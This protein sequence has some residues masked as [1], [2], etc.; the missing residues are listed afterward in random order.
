M[1][2]VKAAIFDADGVLIM[3]EKLFSRQY[4]EEYGLDP[5]SFEAFFKCEF[6]E[7]ITGKA[8][9][10]DL[11]IKHN[12]IW[13]WDNDPQALLDKWFD[14]ENHIDIAVL[15]IVNE[16]RSNKLPVYMA[17]NQ[18]K[19]RA[20]YLR[21]VMFPGVF[22][23]V[24]VSS[25]IGYTK[26]NPKYWVNVLGRLAV[27]IPGVKANNVIFFDDSKDSIEGAR[28]AGIT[29]YLYE[30]VEQIKTALAKAGITTTK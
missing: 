1:S 23:E 24:F 26:S 30:A 21:E 2:E 28:E 14:A 29:A 5:D 25:E 16:L 3:P 11:I 9:L 8:D 7:A 22:D 15:S 6:S 20:K 27:D 17:T 19:Y 18:E 13:H 4:A 10:K 12:D